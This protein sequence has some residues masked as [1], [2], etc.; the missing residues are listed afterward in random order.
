[1][2]TIQQTLAANVETTLTVNGNTFALID[3]AGPVDM[4]FIYIGQSGTTEISK[5]I[6]PFYSETFPGMLTAVKVT[7]A[8][9]QTIKY[10]SGMG[11]VTFNRARFVS[12]QATTQ[13]DNAPATVGV[14][15]AVVLAGSA[16]RQRII[17]TADAANVG[18]IYLGGSGVTTVNSAIKLAAGESWIEE[19][20]AGAAWYGIAS[21]AGQSLRIN[22]AE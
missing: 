8:T 2:R 21:A 13:T 4:E 6:E 3:A 14:A 17:F 10:G 7:S 18:D 16:T 9:A 11:A 22:T 15:A 19:R 1:M 5:G 20:A 12:Q